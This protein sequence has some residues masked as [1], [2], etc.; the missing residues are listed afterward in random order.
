MMKRW[1]LAVMAW[2][3]C[4]SHGQPA[5]HPAESPSGAGSAATVS[6]AEVLVAR[7]EQAL[8][9]SMRLD[10]QR[11]FT[12]DRYDREPV[13]ERFFQ[14]CRAGDHRSCWMVDTVVN[15]AHS[16]VHAYEAEAQAIVRSN[17]GAGDMLSCRAVE[18]NLDGLPDGLP[19]QL[20]RTFAC[21]FDEPAC[22]VAGL[23]RECHA[24]FPESCF[25]LMYRVTPP[26]DRVELAATA[27]QLTRDGCR[28]GIP[29]E[30]ELWRSLQDDGLVTSSPGDRVV[31]LDQLCTLALSSC[32]DL[33]ALYLREDLSRARDALERACQLV[34]YEEF[35]AEECLPIWRLY[36]DPA[37]GIAEPVPDAPSS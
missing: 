25:F 1:L 9:D 8:L 29:G 11:P 24:G 10:Y 23:R 31:V 2:G 27:L 12:S 26:D 13:R 28:V 34:G 21:K 6:R 5:S 14:A 15:R 19:G 3:G 33:G 18:P 17:C 20:G 7:A 35:R 36:T 22:D 30:C 32:K 16:P 37:S 4:G